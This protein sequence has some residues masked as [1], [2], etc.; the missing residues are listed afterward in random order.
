MCSCKAAVKQQAFGITAAPSH[1]SSIFSRAWAAT[2][3]LKKC[4]YFVNCCP[5]QKDES[6]RLVQLS[7]TSLAVDTRYLGQS[8][9]RG[10]VTN[11][12]S[13]QHA[14]TQGFSEPG[15]S[16]QSPQQIYLPLIYLSPSET[17]I[18]LSYHL[19]AQLPPNEPCSLKKRGKHLFSVFWKSKRAPS[20]WFPP[21]TPWLCQSNPKRLAEPNS[22][23][24]YLGELLLI[25]SVIQASIGSLRALVGT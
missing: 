17:G 20:T 12:H 21:S 18:K 7:D 5:S 4:Y 14:A 23:K 11:L 13:L 22:T 25:H 24:Q 15:F 19:T 2:E 10:T 8:L 3:E 9:Q 6:I 1:C 16:S